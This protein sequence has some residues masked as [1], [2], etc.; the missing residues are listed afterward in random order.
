M[1]KII[2]T[3]SINQ[4]PFKDVEQRMGVPSSA[5]LNVP[6]SDEIIDALTVLTNGRSALTPLID[7][8]D[9]NLGYQK[10]RFSLRSENGKYYFRVY[11]LRDQQDFDNVF[12]LDGRELELLQK[13]ERIIKM[14]DPE[15][16][17][18]KVECLMQLIPGTKALVTCPRHTIDIPNKIGN[19]EITPQTKSELTSGAKITITNA[20]KTEAFD[21]QIDLVSHNMLSV[22]E[23][24]NP[25]L[26]SAGAMGQAQEAIGMG[27]VVGNTTKTTKP[28]AS[29]NRSQG[30]LAGKNVSAEQAP[31]PSQSQ[32]NEKSQGHG[33]KR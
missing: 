15:C 17:G 32:S 20:E 30:S 9:Y 2:E 1:D 24:K 26:R 21:V 27:A 5:F 4:I 28:S 22:A 25:L 16:T 7:L 29:K 18:R 19:Q 6:E 3:I 14:A 10:A 11:P 33:F 12:N 31:T 23:N 8:S 13:G